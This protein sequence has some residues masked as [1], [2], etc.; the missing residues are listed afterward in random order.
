[1]KQMFIFLKGKDKKSTL[2]IT[3]HLIIAFMNASIK[4]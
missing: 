2:V 4:I 3:L 1:M